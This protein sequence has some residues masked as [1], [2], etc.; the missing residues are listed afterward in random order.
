MVCY[1]SVHIFQEIK[2]LGYDGFVGLECR[3]KENEWAAAQR[4]YAADQW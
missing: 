1:F 2:E 4:I 3:P